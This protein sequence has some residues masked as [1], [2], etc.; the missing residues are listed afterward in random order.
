MQH[1]GG[2]FT[3]G[4][5]HDRVF[6]LGGHFTDDVNGFGFQLLKMGKP[7]FGRCTMGWPSRIV[8]G[9]IGRQIRAQILRPLSWRA[10]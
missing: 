6:E 1:D 4:I 10:L 2:I 5:Q 7:V 9:R 8:N 3:D